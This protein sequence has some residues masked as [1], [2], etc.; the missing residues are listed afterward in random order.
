M[1]NQKRNTFLIS[2]A[3]LPPWMPDHIDFTDKNKTKYTL[4]PRY[5][6]TRDSETF[7]FPRYLGTRAKKGKLAKVAFI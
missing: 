5:L 1:H 6:G 2:K 7:F 3:R 4:P